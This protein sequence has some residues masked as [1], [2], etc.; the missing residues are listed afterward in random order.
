MSFLLRKYIGDRW[1]INDPFS[2]TTKFPADPLGDLK[3]TDNKLS[4]FEIDDKKSNLDNVIIGLAS[5]PERKSLDDIEYVLLDTEELEKEGFV[6]KKSKGKTLIDKVNEVHRDIVDLT[7]KRL[8][9]LAKI[10]YQ[11]TKIKSFMD[12]KRKQTIKTMMTDGINKGL[13]TS[14]DAEKIKERFKIS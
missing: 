14:K 2:E 10:I 12:Y 11:R 6:I 13:F 8:V 4:V 1:I 7:A 3:T 5:A 9:N